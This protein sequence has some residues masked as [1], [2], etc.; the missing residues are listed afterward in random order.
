MPRQSRVCRAD[1]HQVKTEASA[2]KLFSYCCLLWWTSVQS[3][4]EFVL[5][6]YNAR[7]T[8]YWYRG[9]RRP[10]VEYNFLDFPR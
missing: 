7:S 9:T 4:L 5:F 8:Y 10:I 6:W 2:A 3:R 1:A